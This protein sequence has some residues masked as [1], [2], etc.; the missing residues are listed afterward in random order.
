MIREELKNV[1]VADDEYDETIYVVNADDE[2]IDAYRN[3]DEYREVM[4]GSELFTK[5]VSILKQASE[6]F[7]RFVAMKGEHNEN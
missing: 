1:S 4:K 3:Y 5:W 6:D 2:V 7:E